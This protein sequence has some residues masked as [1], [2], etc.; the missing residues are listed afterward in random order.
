MLNQFAFIFVGWPCFG[1]GSAWDGWESRR[2]WGDPRCGTNE[3]IRPA[4]TFFR[5]ERGNFV[6]STDPQGGGRRVQET[7]SGGNSVAMHTAVFP[8]SV[9]SRETADR[10]YV[11]TVEHVQRIMPHVEDVGSV[12]HGESDGRQLAPAS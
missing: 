7:A 5:K 3:L 9:R 10:P 8:P 6:R 11:S 2:F 12:W 1:A 4:S